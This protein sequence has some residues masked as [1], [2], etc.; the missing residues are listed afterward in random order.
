MYGLLRGA[1]ACGRSC[2]LEW[3]KAFPGRVAL[4]VMLNVRDHRYN[5]RCLG[6]ELVS[7]VNPRPWS[8]A[9]A[10]LPQGPPVCLFKG[11]VLAYG[12]ELGA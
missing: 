8:W 7:H 1:V 3:T 10:R 5:K 6:H 9:R 2:R 11:H 4:L 12:W